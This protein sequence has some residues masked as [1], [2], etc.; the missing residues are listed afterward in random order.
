MGGHLGRQ[1]CVPEE[2]GRVWAHECPSRRPGALVTTSVALVSN[3]VLVTTSKALVP[4]SVALVA[5]RTPSSDAFSS[6]ACRGLCYTG[7]LGAP[8]HVSLGHAQVVRCS[9]QFGVWGTRLRHE[10]NDPNAGIA[11][12]GEHRPDWYSGRRRWQYLI[13]WSRSLLSSYAYS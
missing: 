5:G 12:C 6:R 13:Q 8:D 2:R 9:A 7:L 3:S 11:P 1:S 10:R 4:S